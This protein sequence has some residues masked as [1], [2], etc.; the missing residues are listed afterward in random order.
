MLDLDAGEGGYF[1]WDGVCPRRRYGR[2]LAVS[3]ELLNLLLHVKPGRCLT[4]NFSGEGVR[5]GRFR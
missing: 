5:P 1:F 3:S 4:G 2:S